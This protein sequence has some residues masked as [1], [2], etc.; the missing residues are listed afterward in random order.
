ML[1]T[2]K[3][4]KVSRGRAEINT[5]ESAEESRKQARSRVHAQQWRSCVCLFGLF[6]SDFTQPVQ[7]RQM[8]HEGAH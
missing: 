3:E 4:R 5:R 1:L 8:G 2:G 7:E 6:F